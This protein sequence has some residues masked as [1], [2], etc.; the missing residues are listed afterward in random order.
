MEPTYADIVGS[1]NFNLINMNKQTIF[2]EMM[3]FQGHTCIGCEVVTDLGIEVEFTDDEITLMKQL[4]S[5]IEDEDY[6]QDM[7]LLLKD[8]APELYERIRAKARSA[9]FDFYV[10]DGISQG[11]SVDD[12]V[13][14]DDEPNY[15][16]DIPVEFIPLNW[17]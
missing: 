8:D 13:T 10:V 9:I 16:V 17:D 5:Q 14:M 15:K 3:L 2:F 4:V 12:Q 1:I 11:D 6:S 7:M